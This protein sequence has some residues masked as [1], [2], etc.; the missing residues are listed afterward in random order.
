MIKVQCATPSRSLAVVDRL[1]RSLAFTCTAFSKRRN[2]ARRSVLCTSN[3]KAPSVALLCSDRQVN[4]KRNDPHRK[5]HHGQQQSN[6]EHDCE[7]R[8]A[9]LVRTLELCHAKDK[10]RQPHEKTDSRYKHGYIAKRL[11][12]VAGWHRRRTR[13][14]PALIEPRLA[15]LAVC[16]VDKRPCLHGSSANEDEKTLWRFGG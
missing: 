16:C 8:L 1:A 14:H 7:A 11:A 4:A 13:E 9:I 2:P 15:L 12:T 3:A 5:P 10:H 6:E